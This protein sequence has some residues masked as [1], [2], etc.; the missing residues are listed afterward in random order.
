MGKQTKRRKHIPQRTCL[1][2]RAIR[3]KREL[4]RIVRTPEGA[5]RV[6][7]TGKQNGRGGYV[8]RQQ[9]CWELA[10]RQG[11]LE[12]ALK[13]TLTAET[14][15]QLMQYMSGLPRAISPETEAGDEGNEGSE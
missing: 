13:T 5:V 12:K 2:C 6:D 8:C 10:L 14:E 1:A 9:V 7:E 15:A 3:P 11:Q 4:V